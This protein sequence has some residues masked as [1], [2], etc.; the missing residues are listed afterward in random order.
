MSWMAGRAKPLTHPA[1][2]RG[3][4]DKMAITSKK[5]VVIQTFQLMAFMTALSIVG[6]AVYLH[7][8]TSPREFDEIAWKRHSPSTFYSAK[9]RMKAAV[10]EW[11]QEEKPNQEEIVR[12]LGSPRNRNDSVELHYSL[13][14]G[15]NA[16]YYLAVVL[17]PD[18]SFSSASVRPE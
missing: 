13:G 11:L 5:Q 7:Q 6:L 14:G 8:R 10:I 1:W 17:N 15:L 12:V 18:R 4:G 2:L 3:F 16:E 9:Y